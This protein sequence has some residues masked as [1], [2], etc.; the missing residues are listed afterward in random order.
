MKLD[1]GKKYPLSPFDSNSLDLDLSVQLHATAPNKVD[2]L[3]FTL[4]DPKDLVNFESIN[5]KKRSF[6]LWNH[7]CFEAFFK[8]PDGSYFE[9]NFALNFAWNC[10]YFTSYRSS[11]LTEFPVN[12]SLIARDILLSKDKKILIAKIPQEVKDIL[13]KNRVKCSFTAVIKDRENRTHY[14]ALKHADGK[15][16]FHH[17]DSFILEI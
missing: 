9:F 6:E 4:I 16:N 15:P 14:Y 3:S 12:D 13:N 1:Y 11:P 7:T 8:L 2:L 17:A 10:Y 5:P